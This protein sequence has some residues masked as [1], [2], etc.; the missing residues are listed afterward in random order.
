AVYT[1]PGVAAGWQQA[2]RLIN[3]THLMVKY[4]FDKNNFPAQPPDRTEVWFRGSNAAENTFVIN[5]NKFTDY[6]FGCYA[7]LPN[8]SDCDPSIPN[9]L[10]GLADPK[11]IEFQMVEINNRPPNPVVPKA[12]PA[13]VTCGRIE[14]YVYGT[15]GAQPTKAPLPVSTGT[16]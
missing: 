1:D 11:F 8:L 6:Y 16:N 4:W 14:A 15:A 13:A 2:P 10:Y 12:F 9:S 7:T 5:G 3:I